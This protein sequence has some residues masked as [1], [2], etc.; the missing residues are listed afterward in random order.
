MDFHQKPLEETHLR[1]F[2]LTH[3]RKV[4]HFQSFRNFAAGFL[5]SAEHLIYPPAN[6]STE[7]SRWKSS[8]NSPHTGKRFIR[9][10]NL[11]AVRWAVLEKK[12]S[13]NIKDDNK[14]IAA[15]SGVWIHTNLPRLRS[16]RDTFAVN[17]SVYGCLSCR[18]VQAVAHLSWVGLP[19]SL[20][21]CL[22]K[23]GRRRM[24]IKQPSKR[25]FNVNLN[26]PKQTQR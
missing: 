12:T 25:Y 15:R 22:G 26:V 2:S 7:S 19:T 16:L 10:A 6:D 8:S 17:L 24:D 21:P 13:F 18:L 23:G 20:L 11:E 5:N 9:H 1:E 3:L 4:V 14:L